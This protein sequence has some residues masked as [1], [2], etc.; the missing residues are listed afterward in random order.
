MVLMGR[1]VDPAGEREMMEQIR[2]AQRRSSV[3]TVA[4]CVKRFCLDCLGAASARGAFDCQ[5]RICPLYE[6]SPFRR[7]G[8]RRASKGLV[9]SYCRHCQPG[10]QTDCGGA[11]C[12][13]Y[14][15]RPWQ[16]GGQPRTRTVTDAQKQHL[17]AIGQSSQFRNPWQ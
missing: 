6:S 2:P 12:A 1:R 13:L 3:L 5:S 11:D 15:W 8:R 17:L 10:D 7:I 9:I 16:P 4:A 14:L